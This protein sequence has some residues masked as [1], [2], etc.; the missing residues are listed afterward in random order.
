MIHATKE[1]T[2]KEESLYTVEMGKELKMS[3]MPNEKKITDMCNSSD[4][5]TI[6]NCYKYLYENKY[7]N[8]EGF[9]FIINTTDTFKKTTLTNLITNDNLT[10]IIFGT[11]EETLPEVEIYID[12]PS[13]KYLLSILPKTKNPESFSEW[14]RRLKELEPIADQK[15]KKI[16]KKMLDGD[17]EGCDTLEN[18]IEKV[19]EIENKVNYMIIHQ[20]KTLNSLSNS[21]GSFDKK[22]KCIIDTMGTGKIKTDDFEYEIENF[23][24]LKEHIS[25]ST[26]KLLIFAIEQLNF[27]DGMSNFTFPSY[28]EARE[29]DKN[30]VNRNKLKEDLKILNKIGSIKYTNTKDNNDIMIL[31]HLIYNAA[32]NNG[33][34]FIQFNSKFVEGLK[35]TYM[36]FPKS[37]MK[38]NG[39]E[40]KNVFL[41]GWYFFVQLRV[42]TTTKL[43]RSIKKCLEQLTI[44]IAVKNRRH[45]E[46][47]IEPFENI[48]DALNEKVP[49]LNITFESDYTNFNQFIQGNIVIE[50]NSEHID[51]TYQVIDL[52]KKKK[53][54]KY[55]RDKKVENIS[56]CK[57]YLAEGKDKKEIAKIMNKTVRTIESYIS[58]IKEK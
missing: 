30:Q 20:N 15:T 12:D 32:Y 13:R 44:P 50:L 14:E 51:K 5:K 52:N 11:W 1:L 48:I 39:K 29:I 40:F 37:L 56:I 31:D 28:A 27:S 41:A 4:R 19:K 35:D 54:I 33:N 16:I 25:I 45:K 58:E 36:Y 42:N 26:S 34:I 17:C 24:S 18:F 47:I 3:K 9:D 46:L 21:L 57:Q 7:M 23:K 53:S 22:K 10:R 43:T 8:K 49:E 6:E 2:V 55:N 38:L